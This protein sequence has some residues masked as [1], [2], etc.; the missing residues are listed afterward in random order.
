MKTKENKQILSVLVGSRAHGLHTE[1]SDYDYR[2]V[3]IAPTSDFLRIDSKPKTT[4]WIEG[5]TD[6][7]SWEV[8]HYCFLA[9]RCNPTILETLVSPVEK[10][11]EDGDELR[12]LFPHFLDATYIHNAFKGYSNNQR[13]KMFDKD[14]SQ[15]GH[16]WEKFA[17]AYVRTLWQGTCLF[18][19]GILPI[20]VLPL[21][22]RD[23]MK[24]KNG[25]LSK[26]EAVDLALDW[27]VKIDEAYE[28]N[29]GRF[30]PDINKINEFI[31]KIRR[32]NW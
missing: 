29:K 14:I 15:K 2:G 4:S 24:I 11:T 7:T 28:Q 32:E 23:L 16:R 6:E 22:K 3:F 13:K 19:T 26:G 9:S 30:M 5:D 12:T 18:E 31:L 21:M 17:I 8:A 10:S 25:K 1:D 27:E 20:E